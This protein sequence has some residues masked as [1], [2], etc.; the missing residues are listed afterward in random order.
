[1]DVIDKSMQ[2]QIFT[3]LPSRLR[4]V[5]PAPT[6]YSRGARILSQGIGM[7]AENRTERNQWSRSEHSWR[8]AVRDLRRGLSLHVD[9]TSELIV[10]QHK[11]DKDYRRSD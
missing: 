1:M 8:S 3:S 4:C 10:H 2:S 7:R 5:G 6:R 11:F 9:E